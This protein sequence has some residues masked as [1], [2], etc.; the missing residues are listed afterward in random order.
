VREETIQR[1]KI[2]EFK[3]LQGA[4]PGLGGHLFGEKNT[5]SVSKMRETVICLHHFHSIRC[6]PSKTIRNILTGS[7]KSIPIPWYRSRSPH[8]TIWIWSP[9]VPTMPALILFISTAYSIGI[10]KQNVAMPIEYAISK[11]HN[12]LKDEG[13]RGVAFTDLELTDLFNEK[14]ATQRLTN[15]YHDWN[16]QLVEYCRISA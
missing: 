2:V 8:P 3:Y 6:T 16:V 4:K 13:A 1:V 9:S 11:I 12:F 7:R 10:A 5:E 14:W 15:L